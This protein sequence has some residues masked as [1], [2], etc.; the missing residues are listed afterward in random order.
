MPIPPDKLPL[1]RALLAG[2]PITQELLQQELDRSNK[3]GGVLG[4]ALL[5]SGFPSEEEVILPLL[6]LRIPRINARNTRIP[7]ETI[8]LLPEDVA[9]RHQ[10]L[11]IDQIGSI[12]VVVTPNPA[13]PE[14][15]AASRRASGLVV[16]PIQCGPEGFDEIL[17]DY[18]TRLAESGLAPATPADAGA[19]VAA[20]ASQPTNG[21][22]KAI[23]AG[24]AGQDS[25]WKRYMSPGPIPA[26]QVQ[27]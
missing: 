23:P 21:V 2:G 4:K 11:A 1:G 14:T 6:R 17:T 5:Q 27:M 26:E 16:T 25:F 19:P 13:D 22:V 15:L 20:G 9:R 24:D 8:R 3:A 7:L 18:Y 12:L 10:V